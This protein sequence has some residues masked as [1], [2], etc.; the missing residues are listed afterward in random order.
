MVVFAVL[1]NLPML[2]GTDILKATTVSG[3]MVMGLAPVFILAGLVRYSPLSFHL[4]FWPGLLIGLLLALGALPAGWAIGTG[5]YAMLLGA[6]AYGL[7][8]CTAGFL[9]GAWLQRRGR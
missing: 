3:T 8:I 9:V 4:S 7:P 1:G 5:N 2:A 6:N